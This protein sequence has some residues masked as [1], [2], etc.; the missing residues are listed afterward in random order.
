MY[1]HIYVKNSTEF[2][3]QLKDITLQRNEVLVSFDVISLFPSVPVEAAIE[4]MQRWFKEIN[5]NVN[6]LNLYTQVAK[7]CL[8]ST[9]F[10]FRERF[11]HQESG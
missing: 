8:G 10:Q 7:C 9:F 6:K 1:I 2:C 5:W 11:Y 4:D 3:Q